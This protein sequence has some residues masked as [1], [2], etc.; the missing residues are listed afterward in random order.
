MTRCASFNS[1]QSILRSYHVSK[2]RVA[3]RYNCV[4][5]K[6][7]QRTV[8]RPTQCCSDSQASQSSMTAVM[9][10]SSP[11]SDL[12]TCPFT[13]RPQFRIGSLEA[14]TSIVHTT[15]SDVQFPQSST[16]QPTN[17]VSD[18]VISSNEKNQLV[19]EGDQ[20]LTVTKQLGYMDQQLLKGKALGSIPFTSKCGTRF[21]CTNDCVGGR[22]LRVV[23]AVAKNVTIARGTGT[24]VYSALTDAISSPDFKVWDTNQSLLHLHPPTTAYPANLANTS[25]G[26]TRNNCKITHKPGTSYFSIISIRALEPG[27]EVTVPYGSKFTKDIRKFQLHRESLL[28]ST[29]RFINCNTKI[30]CDKCK[31]WVLNRRLKY[32]IDRINC[33]K[34]QRLNTYK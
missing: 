27:E 17:Q 25:A 13:F 28:R 26:V 7:T 22:G 6:A 31:S 21:R 30:Q 20:A 2:T 23:N 1:K 14:K 24:I 16:S 3:T 5:E 32:H 4:T 19:E 34:L 9:L 33:L 12:H 10:V 29:Q 18:R 15:D 8:T 11:S